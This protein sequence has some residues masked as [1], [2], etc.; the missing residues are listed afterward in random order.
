MVELLTA[1]QKAGDAGELEGDAAQVY[2][3]NRY[4]FGRVSAKDKNFFAGIFQTADEEYDKSDAGKAELAQKQAATETAEPTATAPE[5]VSNKDVK[6]YAAGFNISE[7]QARAELE[8]QAA[9]KAEPTV[10]ATQPLQKAIPSPAKIN[11]RQDALDAFQDKYGTH[12]G[13]LNSRTFMNQTQA[14]ITGHDST[15]DMMNAFHDIKAQ[16]EVA[17]V[18]KSVQKDMNDYILIAPKELDAPYV[19]ASEMNSKIPA[20]STTLKVMDKNVRGTLVGGQYFQKT[21]AGIPVM[22]NFGNALTKMGMSPYSADQAVYQVFNN[23]LREALAGMVKDM[24]VQAEVGENRVDAVLK[25]LEDFMREPHLAFGGRVNTGPIMD[26]RQLSTEEIAKTLSLSRDDA[27]KVAGAINSSMLKVPLQLRGLGDRVVD[28]NYGLNHLAA[29]YARLQSAGKFAINPFFKA[30]QVTTTE[31]FSQVESGGKFPALPIWNKV[32]EMVYPGQAQKL[33]DTVDLLGKYRIISSG[34]S[35]MATE[36]AATSVGVNTTDLLKTEK[37][38]MAGLVNTL[39]DKAGQDP[40]TYIM[41]NREQVADMVKSFTQY[42]RDGNFINSPL[43][44]TINVAFFPARYNIKVA[45]MAAKLLAKQNPFV[46]VAVL[47]GLFKA[48]SWLQSNEGLDWI[49]KNSDAIQLFQWVS[50]LYSLD[51]VYDALNQGIPHHMDQLD[52]YGSLGGLP[53]GLITQSLEAAGVLQGST[54]YIEPSTGE[55]LPSYVPTSMRGR[56]A[57]AIQGILGSLF[58]YPGATAG[59]PT[60]SGLVRN[61]ADW[62]TGMGSSTSAF[63][64]NYKSVTPT[65]LTKQQQHEQDVW[66][67]TNPQSTG[68]GAP[69]GMLSNQY[70]GPMIPIIPPSARQQYYNDEE[71]KTAEPAKASSSTKLKKGQFIP[72]MLPG[73]TQLGVV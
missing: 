50:P 37:L 5:P 11:A 47:Q 33:N 42:P 23:N 15:E 10:G 63:D 59:L 35:G 65:D 58:T 18:P 46:Q 52:T 61:V 36:E 2:A 27:A 38:S 45:G 53:F 26:M 16:N 34:V 32:V 69:G 51:Y 1:F 39:A 24:N 44:K 68:K 66:T 54:P 62:A 28:Y 25:K 41:Q 43:A 55:V 48:Q 29:P 7:T 70:Q 64:A 22:R 13:Y 40:E 56:V 30:Q 49:Q 6:S 73:Q 57:A 31:L 14:I 60:K 19:H 8:K 17:G 3:E 12:T 20:S 72:Q 71:A 4:A 67:G 21:S 9:E